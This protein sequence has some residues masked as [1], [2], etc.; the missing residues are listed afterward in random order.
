MRTVTRPLI[1]YTLPP[2]ERAGARGNTELSDYAA[3]T[4]PT[5]LSPSVIP[6][7]C[8]RHLSPTFVI[9]DPV[10]EWIQA[11]YGDPGSLFFSSFVK[12]RD[13]GTGAVPYTDKDVGTTPCGCPSGMVCGSCGT[14]RRPSPTGFR[15]IVH[16]QS[17]VD[18][19]C[20]A[21]E[22]SHHPAQYA[23]PVILSEAKDLLFQAF[24]GR[25]DEIPSF[26]RP[27]AKLRAY[28][29]QALRSE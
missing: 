19:F 11:I 9:G 1:F 18:S 8:P 22:R 15:G 5:G 28:S 2:W 29:G 17:F 21:L 20:L 24:G 26:E 27:F 13:D 12:T 25:N 16:V 7:A 4:R 10:K 6:D 3:L 14:A 23:S